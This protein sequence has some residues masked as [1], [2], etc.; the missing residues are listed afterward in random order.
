MASKAL[1]LHPTKV[2]PI[3]RRLPFVTE[4]HFIKE[5]DT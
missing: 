3:G 1:D 2:G 5:L 4:F